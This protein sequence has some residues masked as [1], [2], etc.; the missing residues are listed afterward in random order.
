MQHMNESFLWGGL[1][2]RLERTGRVR[3]RT[4]RQEALGQ[5]PELVHRQVHFR[6][7]TPVLRTRFETLQ[8]A[9][10]R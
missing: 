9:R 5:R 4:I 8:T 10:G 2:T 1:R 3:P 6:P 7:A